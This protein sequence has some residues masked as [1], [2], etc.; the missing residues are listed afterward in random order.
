VVQLVPHTGQTCQSVS[1]LF[2]II[3][4]MYG[5]TRC[6][7]NCILMAGPKYNAKES[8]ESSR[9]GIDMGVICVPRRAGF[10]IRQI[11]LVHA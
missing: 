3:R 5:A 1:K 4:I 7:A 8:T 10:R 9:A 6:Q 2:A 11:F